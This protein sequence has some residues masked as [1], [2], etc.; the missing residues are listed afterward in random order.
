MAV[1]KEKKRLYRSRQKANNKIAKK[2]EARKQKG[3]IVIVKEFRPEFLRDRLILE[4]IEAY[5]ELKYL[6]EAFE[7]MN[8]MLIP[9]KKLV[10]MKGLE[11]YVQ[12]LSNLM[13]A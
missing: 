10:Q 4:L 2:V 1:S 5:R 6:K 8:E 13:V 9:M 12:S 3:E 7:G 11:K